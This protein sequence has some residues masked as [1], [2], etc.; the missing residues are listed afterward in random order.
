M[1]ERTLYKLEFN[2]IKDKLQGYAVTE[3]GKEKISALIPS[4]DAAKVTT[5]QKETTDALNMAVK[6]GKVPIGHIKEI[7]SAIKRVEVGGILSSQEILNIVNVLKTSRLL[8][9]YYK[10]DNIDITYEYLNE[11]FESLSVYGD[12][13]HEIGKCII[14]PDEFADDAT[15]VLAQ[16]RKQIKTTNNKIRETVHGIIHSSHYQDMLQEPVV[17]IRQDRYCVPIKVEYKNAFKGIVHDQSSTG[18]TVFMEP[19]SVIELSNNLKLFFAKEEEEIEKI[20]IYL[21]EL[22]AG[23]S[24]LITVSFDTICQLDVIFA[25]AEFA[26]KINGR[27]PKLNTKGYINLKRARHPLLPVDQ[28]VPI[29]VHLGDEFTSLL[30]TGPNTGG[31]TVTLKTV[32]LF[33]LMAQAGMQI[34][35]AEGSEIAIFDDVFADL[36]DEQSIEQSL[37][38]FS[39]HM[40]NIVRILDQMTTNSLILLDEVGSGTDP[41]EGAALAMSILEHLRKQQ[42]RTVATTHYSE[43]KLYALSTDG[44]ENASCEFDV[45]SLRPTYKL[46]IG[47]PGKSNAFA[48]S[49]KLGLAEHLIE[50][51]KVFLH[52]ENVKME[53]IL[54]ELEYNKKI[55]EI[56]KEKAKEFRT[57][58]ENLKEEIKNQRKKLEHSKQKILDRANVKA[59][60]ILKQAEE[61]TEKALKEVRQAARK[62]QVIIDEKGL[63]EVKQNMNETVKGQKHIINK[64]IGPKTTYKKVPQDIQ[65]GEEVIVTHLMQQGVI[66][67]KPDNSGN[68]MVRVGIL[69]IKV[70]I[71]N[72]QR[73][74]QD[75]EKPTNTKKTMHRPSV[76]HKISKT[77]HIKTEVDVRG[78][79][80]DE[81]LPVVDKYLDDAYLS[82]LKQAT[83]IHG[84]GTGAL[85]AAISTMLKRHPHIATFRPGKYGEGEAGVTVVELK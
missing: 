60:E 63:Q 65:E 42:I 46:L 49:M 40:T 43:L 8:K 5:W 79:M 21:T 64:T 41:V 2:K 1:N 37:S 7:S 66:I 61:E 23:I 44:V 9:R 15:P 53:D 14:G 78:M 54:V 38:T 6:K 85:R 20:L 3:R 17:T 11:Y 58:A 18:A 16:I 80:V 30:I 51:A 48:I 34:P 55:A 74:S 4:S 36:G 67:S 33:T 27:E 24:P 73:V 81:A 45:A 26:L 28:V 47:I 71:S 10:D 32:G 59:Q 57:E 19:A 62:A 56:E 75:V 13:E 35:A 39:A 83:I 29:D 82:G 31:K 50:D 12:I 69:P 84:K 76:S 77:S 70:H 68:T 22:I 25:R 72:L 52:K